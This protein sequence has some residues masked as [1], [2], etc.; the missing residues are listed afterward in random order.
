[1]DLIMTK[2]ALNSYL[3]LKHSHVLTD[4]EYKRIIR[5]D[6]ILLKK[7]PQGEKFQNSK[8][9]SIATDVNGRKIPDGFKMK[10]H[11]VGPGKVQLRLPV[12]LFAEAYLCEAYI[13]INPKTEMRMMAKFKT[14]LELIRHK[15][16][17]DCGRLS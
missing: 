4:L 7:Y 9:W 1:M 8:F 6:V 2:W 13:K 14:H 12:G 5:P 11:Q 16:F 15:Q 3:N 10:W 17:V